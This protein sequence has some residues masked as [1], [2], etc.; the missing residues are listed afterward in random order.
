[1]QTTN[2][3]IVRALLPAAIGAG[4]ML[5]F[6]IVINGFA[7]AASAEPHTGDFISFSASAEPAVDG[8]EVTV[9]RDDQTTCTLDVG[10]I[11]HFG[12]S[13]VIESEVDKAAN[14]F[15]VHWAGQHTA[16]DISDCGG[17]ADLMV[18]TQD[19]D[20]LALSAGGYG[21]ES[22]RLPISISMFEK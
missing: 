2:H 1:M 22:K 8:T 9:R 18:D 17:D 14:T 11:R 4:C 13:L 20:V 12:G 6:L 5:T 10:T 21:I 15:R 7:S 16:T 19:L 3:K